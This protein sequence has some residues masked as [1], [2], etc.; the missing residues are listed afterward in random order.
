ML[1]FPKKHLTALKY[2]EIKTLGFRIGEKNLSAQAKVA[3][4]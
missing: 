2:K 3:Y 1:C 4:N